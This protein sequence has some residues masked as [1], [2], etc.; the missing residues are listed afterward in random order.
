MVDY[1]PMVDNIDPVAGLHL[2][3]VPAEVREKLQRKCPEKCAR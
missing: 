3:K 1:R 2:Q